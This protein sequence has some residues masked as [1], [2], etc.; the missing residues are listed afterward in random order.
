[1]SELMNNRILKKAV[2][3]I[4]PLRGPDLLRHMLFP[5]S[6]VASSSSSLKGTYPS[7]SSF[8]S[9]KFLSG[10]GIILLMLSQLAFSGCNL[11]GDANG[12]KGGKTGSGGNNNPNATPTPTP[13]ATNDAGPNANLKVID[14]NVGI[15]L[16]S[17][18]QGNLTV[19]I[20]Q[21]NIINT[22]VLSEDGSLELNVQGGQSPK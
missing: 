10:M 9:Q 15:A 8:P 12:G 22:A 14:S 2:N 20:E 16:D 4:G 7:C 5:P 3:L 11:G 1:M 18:T 13:T 17:Q 21:G 19:T 6:V